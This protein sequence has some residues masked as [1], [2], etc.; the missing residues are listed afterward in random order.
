MKRYN[1]NLSDEQYEYIRRVAYVN[2]VSMAEIF[3]RI[4]EDYRQVKQAKKI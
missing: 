1:I 3:R 2:R 4:I